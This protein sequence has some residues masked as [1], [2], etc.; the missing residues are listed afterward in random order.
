MARPKKEG[1]FLNILLEESVAEL[2]EQYCEETGLSKTVAVERILK[3]AITEYNEKNKE[4]WYKGIRLRLGAF[5][6]LNF[7][8]NL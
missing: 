8:I 6:R 1:K 5:F 7:S 2:L 4:N 3:K